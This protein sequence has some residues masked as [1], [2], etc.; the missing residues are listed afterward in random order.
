MLA[1]KKA[2][3]NRNHITKMDI[4]RLPELFTFATSGQKYFFSGIATPEEKQP[5]DVGI[6]DTSKCWLRIATVKTDVAKK[7]TAKVNIAFVTFE[8]P[9]LGY[10]QEG[11]SVKKFNKE[12]LQESKM[13]DFLETKQK[14]LQEVEAK[15]KEIEKRQRVLDGM[16]KIK[17][18]IKTRFY[19][20]I[21][22]FKK[23][24]D[25][26]D[27]TLLHTFAIRD[28]VTR[29]GTQKIL[30]CSESPTI[31]INGTTVEPSL[32][33][34][35]PYLTVFWSN[36]EITNYI[37][38]KKDYWKQIDTVDETLRGSLSG[39]SIFKFNK[40]GFY[41]NSS[42]NKCARIQIVSGRANKQEE[43]PKGP[44][45]EDIS[46]NVKDCSKI[47]TLIKEG[48]I[49]E[50]DTITIIGKR[51]LAKSVIIRFM[52][53]DKKRHAIANSWIKHLL[54]EHDKHYQGQ[55]TKPYLVCVIGPEKR[56]KNNIFEHTVLV[57]ISQPTECNTSD[58]LSIPTP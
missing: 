6:V 31:P 7:T 49:I 35:I 18:R 58:G 17:D 52:Y 32:G 54:E 10:P 42:R 46:V 24:V 55:Y 3:G 37:E 29:Y 51:E 34:T 23:L 9:I 21:G 19:G 27:G 43:D 13:V 15:N 20:P 2:P 1:D 48:Q 4:S 44:H 25:V 22:N 33:K 16:A 53:K 14:T 28:I 56:S 12:T 50:G 5:P 39:L 36:V 30:L 40:V 41:Y 26:P 47:D 45:M 11:N 38:S 8:F 57:N